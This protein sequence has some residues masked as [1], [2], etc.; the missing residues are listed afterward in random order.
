MTANGPAE[1]PDEETHRAVT[2]ADVLAVQ[3]GEAI[4]VRAVQEST[5]WIL[6]GRV[7]SFTDGT[8]TRHGVEERLQE[9]TNTIVLSIDADTWWVLSEGDT[10]DRSQELNDRPQMQEYPDLPPKDPPACS[11]SYWETGRIGVRIPRPVRNGSRVI[12][13]A[14]DDY[15]S[16]V[17]LTHGAVVQPELLLPDPYTPP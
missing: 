1:N 12:H 5:E 13:Y 17:A 11:L 9:S 2:L 7:T 10:I 4:A 8:E 15:G 14:A 16:V 3:E 6:A